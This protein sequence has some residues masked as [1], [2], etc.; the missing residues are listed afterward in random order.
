MTTKEAHT[1][2]DQKQKEQKKLRKFYHDIDGHLVLVKI[3]IIRAE[4]LQA[5]A[6]FIKILVA[7]A[8]N[9]SSYDSIVFEEHVLELLK[10]SRY[11]RVHIDVNIPACPKN[12]SQ[13][14]IV[15]LVSN[16][17]NNA[18]TA[19][20][21]YG[22]NAFINFSTKNQN[23]YFIISCENS[24]NISKLPV[25]YKNNNIGCGL[26]IIEEEAKKYNGEVKITVDQKS[27]S[28]KIVV[29]LLDRPK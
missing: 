23:E 20:K 3:Y 7:Y 17:I 13:I 12:I 25:N 14:S 19:C 18:N 2:K 26:E 5:L 16:I 24:A 27:N 6:Y 1:S 29:K 8:S 28:F 4:Y 22:K 10:E 11:G 21:S 9:K 15:K